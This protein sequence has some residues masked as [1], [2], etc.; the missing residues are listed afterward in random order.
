[1]NFPNLPLNNNN[2]DEYATVI[3][4]DANDP[5][6]RNH[7]WI[8]D[9]DPLHV[10]QFCR[11]RTLAQGHIL[12]DV[13][14][15]SGSIGW[16]HQK[17]IGYLVPLHIAAEGRRISRRDPK[18]EWS[19]LGPKGAR[20]YH[21]TWD[22]VVQAWPGIPI[23]GARKVV[24]RLVRLGGGRGKGIIE[25]AVVRYAMRNWTSY[26][27]RTGG[28]EVE[29]SA[30]EA[31]V[32]RVVAPRLRQVLKGW[33][34]DSVRAADVEALFERHGLLDEVQWRAPVQTAR[35]VNFS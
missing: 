15:S 35:L 4:V 24:E 14:D 17:H 34:G 21:E 16:L 3:R 29:S 28:V 11:T 33:M 10:L 30:R 26:W 7:E 12:Y 18:A 8:A 23:F 13:W 20:V 31:E 1:M 2:M 25:Q 32:R 19:D 9:T 27:V 5:P 22:A 6:L